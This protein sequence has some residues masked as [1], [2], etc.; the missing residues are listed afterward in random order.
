MRC[1]KWIAGVLMFSSGCTAMNNTEAGA[2]NGGIIGGFT[3]AVLGV[4]RRAIL[5]GCW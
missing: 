2:I 1:S 5:W 3:G 4:W